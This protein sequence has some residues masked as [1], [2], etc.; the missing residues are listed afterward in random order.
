[1]NPS[2]CTGKVGAPAAVTP[3]ISIIWLRCLPGCYAIY[4]TPTLLFFS[5]KVQKRL[6]PIWDSLIMWHQLVWLACL[7]STR[8]V[9]WPSK[10]ARPWPGHAKA[11]L[12]HRNYIKLSFLSNRK[13][14]CQRGLEGRN[15]F[16]NCVPWVLIAEL[17]L[18]SWKTRFISR[19]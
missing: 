13:R 6:W 8:G 18:L 7:Q 15:S 5:S 14:M 10:S 17:N 2:Q 16:L 4:L 19:I 11:G 12:G 1:M 3:H 9:S